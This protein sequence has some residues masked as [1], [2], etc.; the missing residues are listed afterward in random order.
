LVHQDNIPAH[1]ALSVQETQ[2]LLPHPP[3][4]PHLALCHALLFLELKSVFK[5]KK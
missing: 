2:S 5:K 4:N 1:S 3:C